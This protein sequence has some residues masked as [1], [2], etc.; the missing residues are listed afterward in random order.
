MIFV[1]HKTIRQEKRWKSDDSYSRWWEF[2]D[3][4]RWTWDYRQGTAANPGDTFAVSPMSYASEKAA[5]SAIA[6]AR[7]AFGGARMAKVV[8]DV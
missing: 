6:K 5:R 3:V 7:K 8:S 1:L 4:E 2:I